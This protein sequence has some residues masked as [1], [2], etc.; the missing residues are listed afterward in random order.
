MSI[1]LS[2]ICNKPNRLKDVIEPVR[3]ALV[4]DSIA[5]WGVGY[6]QSHEILLSRHPRSIR[7]S[8]DFYEALKAIQSETVIGLASTDTLYSGTTNTQPFRFLHWMFAME[9]SIE[10]FQEVHSLLSATL[11]SF[12]RQSIKGKTVAEL[13]FHLFLHQLH[14]RSEIDDFNLAPKTI[15]KALHRAI[16]LIQDEKNKAGLP[17]HLGN[18]ML[19]N[20]RSLLCARLTTPL[21]IRSLR[22]LE[23]PKRPDTEFRSILV[24]GA[25]EHPGEGFEEIPV[26]SVARISRNLTIEMASWENVFSESPA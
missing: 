3:N 12:L 25:N 23:D 9:S 16:A 18:I 13:A 7:G 1:F 21:F 19:S 5:R 26:H 15:S 20:T 4:S 11:P 22:V 14:N 17:G 8:F 6:S 24:I 10:G 2:C